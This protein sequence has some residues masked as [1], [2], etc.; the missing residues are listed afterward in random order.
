[1]T[2]AEE[3]EEAEE[4]E[5]VLQLGL[6]SSS[7]YSSLSAVLFLLLFVDV[8]VGE[9]KREEDVE[10]NEDEEEGRTEDECAEVVDAL[11]KGLKCCSNTFCNCCSCKR[12]TRGFNSFS[13]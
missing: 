7:L 2:K 5:E 13:S 1:L 12:V 8:F 3:A 11:N 4:W 9:W 6:I 10:G